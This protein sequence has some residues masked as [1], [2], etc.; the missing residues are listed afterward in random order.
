MPDFFD[1]TTDRPPSYW[2]GNVEYVN[3]QD[4]YERLLIYNKYAVVIY[5]TQKWCSSC[6]RMQNMIPELAH[7]Y[8]KMK[9]L[10][11][12]VDNFYDL[13]VREEVCVFPTMKLF[14]FAYHQGTITGSEPDDVRY[15]ASVTNISSSQSYFQKSS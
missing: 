12:D 9:F 15:A 2:S 7:E 11:I 5:I 8:P 14:V 3:N 4:D 1:R 13:V 10:I 6:F